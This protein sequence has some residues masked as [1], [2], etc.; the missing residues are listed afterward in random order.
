[1]GYFCLYL[2]LDE[3][4]TVDQMVYLSYQRQDFFQI[5]NLLHG[6]WW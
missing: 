5:I 3:I 2:L 4:Y 6:T 1:M